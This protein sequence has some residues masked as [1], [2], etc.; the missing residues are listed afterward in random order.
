MSYYSESE[1]RRNELVM[2]V[3]K[4]Q[5]NRNNRILIKEST[6]ENIEI[7]KDNITRCDY[8]TRGCIV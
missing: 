6:N 8:D 1:K 4:C 5:L 2:V 3:H 7:L